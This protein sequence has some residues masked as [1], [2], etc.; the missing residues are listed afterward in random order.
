MIGAIDSGLADRLVGVIDLIDG[1][2]VHA[3]AGNR[4]RYCDVAFCGGDPL[5]LAEHYLA[6]GLTRIYV[7]DLNALAG[8]ALQTRTLGRLLDLDLQQVLV[9]IGWQGD[10][11]DSERE[12]LN[13][14]GAALSVCRMDCRHGVISLR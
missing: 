3:I 4:R 8:K 2:A 11:S 12:Q 7:A 14:S 5:L 6:L 13:R 9:D 10:E 1:R